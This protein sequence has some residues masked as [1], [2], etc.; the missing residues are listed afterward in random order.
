MGPD[1]ETSQHRVAVFGIKVLMS[2]SRCPSCILSGASG[3]IHSICFIVSPAMVALSHC[4][5]SVRCDISWQLPCSGDTIKGTLM[6]YLDNLPSPCNRG[7]VE[8]LTV[9]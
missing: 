4:S 3:K 2:Y 5:P 7:L 9:S 6:Y 1:T 8:K